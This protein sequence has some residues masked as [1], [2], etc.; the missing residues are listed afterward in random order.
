[1][2]IADDVDYSPTQDSE[3]NDIYPMNN[4]KFTVTVNVYANANVVTAGE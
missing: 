3:G 2:W 4:K 1:M